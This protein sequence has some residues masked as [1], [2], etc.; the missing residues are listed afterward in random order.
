[1]TTKEMYQQVVPQNQ[2]DPRVK[3][4]RN[5]ILEALWDLLLEKSIDTISVRDITERATVSRATF[6]DHFKDKHDLFEQ[7]IHE[8]IQVAFRGSASTVRQFS[9][10]NLRLLTS[11]VLGIMAQFHDRRVE[12]ASEMQLQRELYKV[13]LGWIEQRSP[14]TAWQQMTPDAAAWVTSCMVFGAGA[15]WGCSERTTSADRRAAEIVTLLIYGLRTAINV[16]SLMQEDRGI[17]LIDKR[18]TCVECG[19]QFTFIVEDQLIHETRGYSDP[20]RCRP[21]RKARRQRPQ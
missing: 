4:T 2:T 5:L 17:S 8:A 20:K 13:L 12:R 1:V 21:C 16:G 6:Y 9:L 11:A 7:A 3:R 19:Q 18:I 15:E 10:T 14:G